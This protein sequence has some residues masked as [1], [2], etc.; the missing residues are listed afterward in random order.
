MSTTRTT[1]GISLGLLLSLTGFN[2]YADDIE[3]VEEPAYEEAQAL[4]LEELRTFGEVF[5]RIKRAYVHDVDDKDLLDDAIRGMISGLDPHSSYLTPEDYSELQES[6]Q[7]EF[8]GLGLEVSTENGFIKVITPID[9]TPAARADIRPHDLIVKINDTPVKNLPLNKSIE[10]MR[11]KPDTSIRLTIMRDGV[12]AP[13][14]VT[15]KRALIRV[16][17]VKHRMLDKGYGYIRITQFQVHTGEEVVKALAKMHKEA[18]GTLNG[19]VLDLR[20]NPGGVLQAAAEVV[21]AFITQGMIVY[22]KGR[23]DNAAMNFH[24]SPS[25]PSKGAPLIVLINEG[26]ASASEIVSGALQDHKRGIIMG[27][28]SFGKGSVQT[29][30]PLGS[31]R[32]LKLTTALYYTPSGRSIQAQGITPDIE[33]KPAH[34]TPLEAKLQ[35]KEADLSGHLESGQEDS[36]G[37]AQA[38]QDSLAESDYQLFE[39]LS[40]LKGLHI[41]QK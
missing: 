4:P 16:T 31:D 11:G 17:S 1:L 30:L 13:F 2:L 37:K 8:G 28:Q 7:G 35:I 23:L 27:T 19:I 20:N 22:T 15:L 38:P 39:A 3:P 18:D 36:N 12:D 26:S 34:L 6:T 10:L 33:V 25:D 41:L 9:D 14:E 29:I 5:E 21:D 40:L 24:A 32:G